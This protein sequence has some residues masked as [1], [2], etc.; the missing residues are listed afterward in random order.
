MLLH[1]WQKWAYYSQWVIAAGAAAQCF[2][3]V[4]RLQLPHLNPWFYVLIFTCTLLQYML[5]FRFFIFSKL[6]NQRQLFFAGHQPFLWGQLVLAAIAFT[7]SFIVAGSA[8]IVPLVCFGL[9]AGAYSFFLLRPRR[10]GIFRYHG[11]FKI[12]TLTITWAGVTG[13]LPVLAAQQVASHPVYLFHFMMRWLMMLAICLPFDARDVERDRRNGT[14]T[15][16]AIIGIK[17]AFFVCYGCI[18]LNIFM[19][20]LSVIWG[21]N[22]RPVAIAN[23]LANVV[24]LASIWYSSRHLTHEFSWFLLD[25]NFVIHALIVT[26]ILWY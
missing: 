6:T 14:V 4:I 10:H 18:L 7:A 22:T 26:A 11:L 13:V 5:H 3:T 24:M 9:L 16:P 20:G 21:W 12:L 2:E 23:G 15:I 19:V 25:A 8:L 17:N 1:R